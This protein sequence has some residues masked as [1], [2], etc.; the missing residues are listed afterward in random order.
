MP[1]EPSQIT[2]YAHKTVLQD[3][4]TLADLIGKVPFGPM[5]LCEGRSETLKLNPAQRMK[6][7]DESFFVSG[8]LA[9]TECGAVC[10]LVHSIQ[11]EPAVDPGV[12]KYPIS[13]TNAFTGEASRVKI[14]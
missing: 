6:Q 3:G 14:K 4:R 8:L 7:P 10:R 5:E 2:Y 9:A 11:G 13:Y 1:T 12:F